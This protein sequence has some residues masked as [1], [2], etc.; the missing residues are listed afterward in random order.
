M[1]PTDDA[2]RKAAW[3][4]YL[5]TVLNDRALRNRDLARLLKEVGASER[6]TNTS[7]ISQWRQGKVGASETAALF[8]AKALALPA[9][10]VLRAAGH[11]DAARMWEEEPRD[12]DRYAAVI[13][14][15]GLPE[16]AQ[17]VAQEYARREDKELQRRLDE[18]VRLL[19]RGEQIVAAREQPTENT[20]AS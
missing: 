3:G 14:N 15:S 9:P 13:R 8:V 17:E 18:Y 10:E 11:D 2:L 6:Y 5:D 4:R 19:R 1:T 20:D 7:L 12:P 16:P